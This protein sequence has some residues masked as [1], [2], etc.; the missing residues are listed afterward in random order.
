MRHKEEWAME[1]D[2]IR[3]ERNDELDAM[4][5]ENIHAAA[6]QVTD[7]LPDYSAPQ[8]AVIMGTSYDK[9]ALLRSQ[10]TSISSNFQKVSYTPTLH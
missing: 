8:A 2:Q 7:K 3:T 5:T 10:P 1:V 9:R 4:F 6:R